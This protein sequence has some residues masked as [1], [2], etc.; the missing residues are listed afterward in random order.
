MSA[1]L[2]IWLLVLGPGEPQNELQKVKYKSLS[3][4]IADQRYVESRSYSELRRKF[5]STA[6]IAVHSWCVENVPEESN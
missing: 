1:M 3:K 2:L 6:E 4:C 5:G